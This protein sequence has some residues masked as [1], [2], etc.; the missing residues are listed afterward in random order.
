MTTVAAAPPSLARL[1]A[2]TPARL[3]IGRTGPR[4]RTK[5]WLDLVADHARA[6]DAVTSEVPPALVRR[7]G[8]V[9]IATRAESRQDYVRVPALGRELGRGALAR[10]R[11]CRQAPQVQLA[12][13]DGLS[14]AAIVTNGAALLTALTRELRRRRRK[15]GTPLFVRNGRV[16]VQ[17][18]IGA[19]LKPEV[20]C[21]IVGERPGLV[22]A[23][24]LSAY[25]IYRPSRRSA[26]PD[27]TVV[28]NIHRGGIAPAVAARRLADLL[29]EILRRGASGAAL[30]AAHDG[31]ARETTR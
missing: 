17:D 23:E 29:D 8:L 4:L 14:S 9:E 28:S 27:R 15:L 3:A 26:E 1:L 7:L 13:T 2:A 25:V 6:R 10:L 11:R 30:A 24:S 31:T 21:F 18:E 20:F 12:L 22:T 16:R 19:V 5:T